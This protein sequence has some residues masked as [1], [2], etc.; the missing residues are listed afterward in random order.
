MRPRQNNEAAGRNVWACHSSLL[1]RRHLFLHWAVFI[2]QSFQH[3]SEVHLHMQICMC[4]INV[5]LLSTLL[6]VF[7][8]PL[9]LLA[10]L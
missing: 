3:V 4:E 1:G 8:A 9:V 6:V 2:S 5:R 10:A 7:L